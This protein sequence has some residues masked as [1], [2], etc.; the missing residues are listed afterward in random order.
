[1][2]VP[3]S[4]QN[5]PN[6]GDNDRYQRTVRGKVAVLAPHAGPACRELFVDTLVPDGHASKP[7]ERRATFI[8]VNIYRG[9]G[10]ILRSG[11]ADGAPDHRKTIRKWDSMDS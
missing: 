9:R 11:L 8:I 5:E 7:T 10:S 4:Q 1:M 6:I 3:S 2:S